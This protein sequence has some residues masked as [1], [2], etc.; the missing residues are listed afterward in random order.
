[1]NNILNCP[2]PLKL[3]VLTFFICFFVLIL[4]SGPI[5]ASASSAEEETYKNLE[6]FANVLSILKDNYV[7]DIN[8]EE[9]IQ[10]AIKGMLTSLDP[11]SSYLKPESYKDLQIETQGSFSGIGIEVTIKDGVLIVVSPIEGTPADE[12]GLKAGDKII[13]IGNEFTKDL[14]LMEAV[15]LLRGEKG[16][17]VTLSI[18]REGWTDL[19]NITITRDVIPLHS[20]KA[21]LLDEGYAYIRIT[22][23]QAQTTKETQEALLDLQKGH[24]IK[25]LILDLRNNPGGL[26][27]QA[28]KISDL[29]LDDGIIV[30]T[31]GRIKNQNMEF[32]AHS[33]GERN[34]FPI[35]ILVNEGSASASEIVAGALQDHKR[36][37]VLGVQTFGK[38]SVQT[39]IPMSNGAGLRLTTARYYTPNGTSIQAKGIT[40]DIKV[41]NQVIP[42]DSDK[43]KKQTNHRY[44]REK[45]LKR[46]I[47]N[48]IEIDAPAKT[49]GDAIQPENENAAP[50]ETEN[51]IQN[52]QQFKAALMLL[53]GLNVLGNLKD[54]PQLP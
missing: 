29:F 35:I 26:L 8:P 42:K 44:I 50:N 2:S 19:H 52:D 1:M 24:P 45:D 31:K 14:T 15:H 49:D 18:H 37:L 46:H 34:N 32:I 43:E 41:E 20:V 12:K 54:S 47:T 33:D 4:Q 3:R 38:G 48:G 11:H 39:V 25:G 23:F 13:K 6:V 9:V 28:I 36:A 27:D 22:N 5:P 40:P 16:S 51:E 30:S 17:Q 53:K 7:E 10:G 21:K